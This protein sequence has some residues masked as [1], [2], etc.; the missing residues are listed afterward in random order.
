MKQQSASR[1]VAP[2]GHISWHRT[3]ESLLSPLN[4][5][6]LDEKLEIPITSVRSSVILLLPLFNLTGDLIYNLRHSRRANHYVIEIFVFFFKLTFNWI[7][8]RRW[9]RFTDL[10]W[11]VSP[12]RR[13]WR[14]VDIFFT[15]L[16]TTL[17]SDLTLYISNTT[18]VI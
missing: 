7:I 9:C 10:K 5:V 6:C 11:I 12:V 18:S 16:P 15:L 1:H 4:G 13:V 8:L 2:L 14:Y 3:N 17:L